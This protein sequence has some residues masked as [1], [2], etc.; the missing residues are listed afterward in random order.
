MSTALLLIDCQNDFLSSDHLQPNRSQLI[1]AAADL[2]ALFRQSGHP[3]VHIW[4]SIEDPRQALP[5][6]RQRQPMI[7]LRGSPGHETP[8]P[9]RPAP[10]ELVLHKQGFSG[11]ANDALATHL[12]SLGVETIALAGVHLR[13]CIRATAMDGHQRGWRVWIAVEACGDD[14][15]LHG[16]ISRAWMDRRGMVSISGSRLQGLLLNTEPEHPRQHHHHNPAQ[17]HRLLW[18]I[19]SPAQ[20]E[21]A[22]AV[23]MARA[24]QAHWS[25]T[26]SEARRQMLHRLERALAERCRELASAIAEH[27]GKPIALATMELRFA[28]Q[29]IQATRTRAGSGDTRASGEGWRARRCPLGVVAAITP[30]NNPVAIPLGKLAP[31]LLH[32]AGVPE[33]VVVLLEGDAET[34]RALMDQPGIDA[35]TL[36]GGQP[37]AWQPGSPAVVGPCP[38]RR[39]WGATTPP[40]SGAMPIR[41]PQRRPWPLGPSRPP[42][43]AAPPIAA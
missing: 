5:H 8:M 11:F 34:A 15:P 9:L 20:P 16:E 14:D 22:A 21:I 6:W 10:G 1:A 30:W 42:A 31:A 23:A 37:P 18:T 36:T 28:E 40:S 26:S 4:T 29:L 3:V 33:G 13:T 19:E 2:L 27:T 12:Q 39:N 35:I 38:C 41:S 43:S 7:C 24:A 25:A 32:A 17:P